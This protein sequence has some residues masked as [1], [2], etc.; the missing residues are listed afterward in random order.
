MTYIF[1]DKTGT[2]TQNIMAFKKC[3]IAGIEFGRG[4]CEVERAIARRRGVHLPPDPEPPGGLD[5]GFEFVDERLLFGAWR[6]LPMHDAVEKF[7]RSLAVNHNV[8]VEIDPLRPN[9]PLYQV[10]ANLKLIETYK[11]LWII[12]SKQCAIAS[13]LLSNL[14]SSRIGHEK[15]LF[16]FCLN[17]RMNSNVTKELSLLLCAG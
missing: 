2:L 14:V 5:P 8:Q 9:F 13:L 12:H 4:Y 16:A 15:T 1:S 17:A 11:K 10:S 7:L 6:D 3:S